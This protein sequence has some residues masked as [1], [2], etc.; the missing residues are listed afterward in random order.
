MIWCNVFDEFVCKKNGDVVVSSPTHSFLESFW[1]CCLYYPTQ[2]SKNIIFSS[3]LYSSLQ[4]MVEN[5]HS[6][7]ERQ[8]Y[9]AKKQAD[10]EV[11]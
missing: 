11:K 8:A 2:N 10:Q 4:R 7:R 1:S 6:T 3:L 9:K 5:M